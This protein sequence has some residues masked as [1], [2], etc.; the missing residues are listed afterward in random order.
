M[1]L[2]WVVLCVGAAAFLLRVL[3]A[4]VNELKSP[5]HR[6]L[7]VP[8]ATFRPSQNRA[9]LVEI[10]SLSVTR[11]FRTDN[12]QRIAIFLLACLGVANTASTFAAFIKF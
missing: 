12:G 10:R 11:R 7:R 1:Q 8:R 4:L 9:E 2:F 3:A 6:A 5:S